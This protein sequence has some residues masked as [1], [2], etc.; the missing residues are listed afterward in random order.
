[1]TKST[2]VAE[3]KRHSTKEQKTEKQRIMSCPRP[4]SLISGHNHIYKTMIFLHVASRLGAIRLF[5][6]PKHPLRNRVNFRLARALE[7]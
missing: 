2:I 4:L 7:Q 3:H 1:M 5:L 6:I